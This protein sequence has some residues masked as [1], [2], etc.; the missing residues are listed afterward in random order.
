[1]RAA[2]VVI[3]AVAGE[4]GVY[5]IE[6]PRQRKWEI[7]WKSNC[8]RGGVKFLKKYNV[9]TKEKAYKT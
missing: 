3:V 1:M 6:A 2:V 9:I 5:S 4:E 8:D 7:D